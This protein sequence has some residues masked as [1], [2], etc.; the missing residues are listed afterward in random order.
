MEYRDLYDENR[1]LTG[2]IIK[3]GDPIPSNRY[4]LTVMVFIENSEGLIL[5]QERS[6]LKG[7]F[8]ATTGGHPKSGE[9]SVEGMCTEIKEELGLKVNPNEL[10]LF[11]SVKSTYNFLDLYY[12]K[13]EIDINTLV[14][15]EEEVKDVNWF[16]KEQITQLISNNEFY[17]R[18]IKPYQRFLNFLESILN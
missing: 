2:E 10:T 9:T 18:H 8:W 16:T 11:A 7:G 15:Q 17:D 5:L 14:L 6:P 1:N 4:F 13:K 12:L 3:K